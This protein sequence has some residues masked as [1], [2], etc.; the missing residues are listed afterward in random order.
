[1]SVVASVKVY[2]GIVLGAESMTA[3]FASL[4]G[5]APQWVKSYANA[6]KLFQIVERLGIL[7]YGAGN[8]GPRSIESFAHEF[9]RAEMARRKEPTHENEPLDVGQIA[10][11]FFAFLQGHYDAGFGTL[12]DAQKPVMGFV[13]AGYCDG[14]HLASW[15]EFLLPL[16][17][18]AVEIAPLDNVGAIWRGIGTPFTRLMFGIDPDF[19]QR[20]RAGGA[21]DD[22][23]NRFQTVAQQAATQ[24]AFNGMPL[25]DAV[26]YC[27]FIIQTTIGWC[28]YAPGQAACGGPIKL[29]AITPGDGFRWVT[30]QKPYLEG[31]H[32]A[33]PHQE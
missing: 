2:D 19:E 1:M 27:R 18:E 17:T 7:T 24:V 29:A 20:L 14:Q 5:Q 30:R 12:P 31:E 8:I 15:W 16:A 33:D 9:N 6:Q 22:E 28:K 4:P 13:V 26:G 21:S 11:R 25:A 3:L 32:D 10:Q 23:V